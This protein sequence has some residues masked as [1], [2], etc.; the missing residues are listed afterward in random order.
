[1]LWTKAGQ[2]DSTDLLALLVLLVLPAMAASAIQVQ[3]QCLSASVPASQPSSHPPARQPAAM[4]PCR[5]VCRPRPD[6][7]SP[8]C[9]S[10]VQMG[11]ASP[12]SALVVR[13]LPVSLV[14][15]AYP[16]LCVM[17]PA[18]CALRAAMLALL[19]C[20]ELVVTGS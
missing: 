7:P 18:T 15:A 20:Y 3:V 4:S 1:M 11:Q 17:R 2:A 13:R 12:S 6:F 19:H 8:A 5:P 16:A 14:R 10:N 9:D